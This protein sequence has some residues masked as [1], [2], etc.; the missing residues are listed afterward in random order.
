MESILSIILEKLFDSAWYGENIAGLFVFSFLV[1]VMVKFLG[2]LG[3]R[4]FE[5]WELVVT[6]HISPDTQVRSTLIYNEDAKRMLSNRH[7]LFVTLRQKVGAYRRIN[8]LDAN[9]AQYESKWLDIRFLAWPWCWFKGGSICINLPKIPPKELPGGKWGEHFKPR[10]WIGDNTPENAVKT[11]FVSA[12]EGALQWFSH[13]N[14]NA[15]II[16][17]LTDERLGK[18]QNGD[19]VIGTLPFHLVAKLVNQKARYIHLSMD[20]PKTARD[21]QLSIEEMEKHHARL[22]EYETI[23]IG[24]YK[25]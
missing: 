3:N 11:L 18:L 6:E 15:E 9:Q 14:I 25:P 5:G 7:E 10:G 12:H 24:G 23:L 1:S 20:L 22:E 2:W 17:H 19:V 13:L 8:T 21:R 4:R 16:E